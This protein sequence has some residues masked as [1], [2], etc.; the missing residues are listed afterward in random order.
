MVVAEVL[1]QPEKNSCSR[2]VGHEGG[3]GGRGVETAEKN[4]LRLAFGHEGGGGGGRHIG[5]TKKNHLRLAFGCEGGDDGGRGVE[6]TKKNYLWPVFGREGGGGGGRAVRVVVVDSNRPRWAG[7]SRVGPPLVVIIIAAVSHRCCAVITHH[8]CGADGV[9]RLR[10]VHYV[11][12][13]CKV[14]RTHHMGLPFHGSPL[15]PP[16]LSPVPSEHE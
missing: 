6:T 16:P 7:F 10:F 1:K 11:G 8:R 4:H 14:V 15:V 12:V 9:F 5:T 13:R 3:G 2:L